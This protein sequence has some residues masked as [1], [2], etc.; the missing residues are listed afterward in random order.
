MTIYIYDVNRMGVLSRIKNYYRIKNNGCYWKRSQ[1]SL[2]GGSD[3]KFPPAS[4]YVMLR[5]EAQSRLNDYLSG[6]ASKHNLDSVILDYIKK[7][8]SSDFI[9]Y[10]MFRFQVDRIKDDESSAIFYAP[11]ERMINGEKADGWIDNV[12]QFFKSLMLFGV[13]AFRSLGLILYSSG[14]VKVEDIVYLRK[15]EK[16]DVFNFEQFERFLSNDNCKLSRAYPLVRPRLELYGIQY[17]NAF[18]GAVLI[19]LRAFSLVLTKGLPDLISIL[20]SRLLGRLDSR[21]LHHSLFIGMM[22]EMR[23]KIYVGMLADKPMYNLMYKYKYS[24]QTLVVYLDGV[25]FDGNII[26]HDS[27][28]SDVCLLSDVH[29]IGGFN[30]NGGFCGKNELVGSFISTSTPVSGCVSEELASLANNY[31]MVVM[32]A[33]AQFNSSSQKYDYIEDGY[34][35]DFLSEFYKFSAERNDVLFVLKEKKGEFDE[36]N[37]AVFSDNVFIVRTQ[38]PKKVK[39]N[40]FDHILSVSDIVV[41]LAP[42]SSVIPSALYANKLPLIYNQHGQKTPWRGYGDIEMDLNSFGQIM[43]Y[44]IDN[45]DS[46][47]SLIS[48]MKHGFMLD[49]NFYEEASKKIS[50]ILSD[51]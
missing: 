7:S 49:K 12:G 45:Y 21:F 3:M 19:W 44:W 43:N 47:G 26:Y 15:Q 14:N 42:N 2:N 31:S 22:I 46:C 13:S 28:Y 6:I 25:T 48:E 5:I 33:S 27:F 34:L 4:E 51:N 40:H 36:V 20:R 18:E 10:Y 35:G 37:I 30:K 23:A 38:D 8:V 39:V 32:I 24:D 11:F 29:V 1:S 16:P 50:T 9:D 17:I 41:S